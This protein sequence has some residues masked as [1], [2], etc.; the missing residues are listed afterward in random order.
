MR[1]GRLFGAFLATVVLSGTA[2]AQAPAIEF[3][4]V[5][6]TL[7]GWDARDGHRLP[8]EGYVDVYLN[9]PNDQAGTNIA[10]A[11]H[12]VSS[13]VLGTTYIPC[14]GYSSIFLS[15]AKSDPDSPDYDPRQGTI[16][17]P[18]VKSFG[19]NMGSTAVFLSLKTPLLDTIEHSWIFQFADLAARL[20]E[21]KD[22]N[23]ILYGIMDLKK[24]PKASAADLAFF[25]DYRGF[26]PD[27]RWWNKESCCSNETSFLKRLADQPLT[28]VACPRALTEQVELGIFQNSKNVSTL[29]LRKGK[30]L[31][32]VP[33][34][35]EASTADVAAMKAALRDA[36][37]IAVE[38]TL[39]PL[40]TFS[41]ADPAFGDSSDLAGGNTIIA[42]WNAARDQKPPGPRDTE[43]RLPTVPDFK[44]DATPAPEVAGDRKSFVADVEF[45]TRKAE[46]ERSFDWWY[47]KKT[48]GSPL[49]DT[50]DYY[51]AAKRC[52]ESAGTRILPYRTRLMTI[53]ELKN[54]H[55][56]LEERYAGIL[57]GG[58]NNHCFM[59][60][61]PTPETDGKGFKKTVSVIGRGPIVDGDD[62]EKVT[63]VDIGKAPENDEEATTGFAGCN[64]V[65]V[66]PLNKET[67]EYGDTYE[68][69]SDEKSRMIGDGS[70][71]LAELSARKADDGYRRLF[72]S[73]LDPWL[74]FLA[75]KSPTATRDVFKPFIAS[76]VLLLTD[77]DDDSPTA[78][79]ASYNAAIST[80]RAL[81]LFKLLEDAKNNATGASLEILK[82]RIE[83]YMQRLWARE[84]HAVSWAD[85]FTLEFIDLLDR[86]GILE[87][88]FV[89]LDNGMNTISGA[90]GAVARQLTQ[91]LATPALTSNM[92]KRA[93]F[94]KNVLDHCDSRFYNM[95]RADAAVGWG[96]CNSRPVLAWIPIIGSTVAFSESL[97]AQLDGEPWDTKAAVEMSFHAGL[98]VL[99]VATLGLSS[100]ARASISA[101]IKAS[102]AR[103]F[104]ATKMA[105]TTLKALFKDAQDLMV[106]MFRR[107]SFQVR[108]I[109]NAALAAAHGFTQAVESAF[110]RSFLEEGVQKSI[111]EWAA[112]LSAKGLEV[113]PR[114]VAPIFGAKYPL[115]GLVI[116]GATATSEYKRLGNIG[117]VMSEQNGGGIFGETFIFLPNTPANAASGLSAG[118]W[119]GYRTTVTRHLFS[120]KGSLSEVLRHELLHQKINWL[121]EKGILSLHLAWT[122]LRGLTAAQLTT[123][124]TGFVAEGGLA[125]LIDVMY[126]RPRF[127]EMK[128]YFL[129]GRKTMQDVIYHVSRD[130]LGIATIRRKVMLF[131]YDALLAFRAMIKDLS[132]VHDF[133]KLYANIYTD[134]ARAVENRF[135]TAD[136]VFKKVVKAGATPPAGTRVYVEIPV[137]GGGNANIVVTLLE[138]GYTVPTTRIPLG[139]VP[140]VAGSV[141]E[142]D[143][144]K[145]LERLQARAG[146]LRSQAQETYAEMETI[147]KEM[148]VAEDKFASTGRPTGAL[149][150]TTKT[151]LLSELEALQA[152]LDKFYRSKL[153]DVRIVEANPLL[154]TKYKPRSVDIVE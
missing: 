107:P 138:G 27:T 55:E 97:A 124:K 94:A 68:R 48:E 129:S 145:V 72:V 114:M 17:F 143:A 100:G 24:G 81:P 136:D 132:I 56:V 22:D 57:S 76:Y 19:E 69:F 137:Q 21:P 149:K 83:T 112:E 8:A 121:R 6:L 106:A 95:E 45:L 151:P 113:E 37:E 16:V 49:M 53:D 63:R 25:G 90:T 111:G 147:L 4:T 77:K 13:W 10:K 125:P 118:G 1:L 79:L 150:S 33:A 34:N 130:S 40:D 110:T 3:Q 131:N 84:N 64:Y 89:A 9:C 35:P 87:Q 127:D 12:D 105:F 75:A 47:L 144:V 139:K 115:E 14:Q 153:Y 65:C 43:E 32:N 101:A 148:K 18:V 140:F 61:S 44:A 122:D 74:W 38:A 78:S 60:G 71:F 109:E 73:G 26:A 2:F 70:D 28:W 82:S 102:M 99:D 42:A 58:R 36:P 134:V 46:F 135:V 119:A 51:T 80:N 39:H 41:E 62:K 7:K 120:L 133:A 117:R 141:S 86:N 88:R 96:I 142:V 11:Q 23:A 31:A 66:L 98:L 154:P 152:R 52:R 67:E 85:L 104:V 126:R 92:K 50:A 103:S 146:T 59:S 20:D 108:R 15:T 93:Y 91:A 54:Y 30:P 29:Y 116:K 123:L 128:A 5:R